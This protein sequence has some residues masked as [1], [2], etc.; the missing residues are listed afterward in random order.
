MKTDVDLLNDLAKGVTIT[1]LLFYCEMVRYSFGKYVLVYGTDKEDEVLL[2]AITY[3]RAGGDKLQYKKL[4]MSFDKER[5]DLDKF[6]AIDH[7][8]KKVIDAFARIDKRKET[9]EL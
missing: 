3:I 6:R 9:D 1:C 4:S 2:T 8:Q 5:F 7:F